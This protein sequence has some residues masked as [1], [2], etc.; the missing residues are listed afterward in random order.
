MTDIEYLNNT[1]FCTLAP[2]AIHGVGVFAVRDI[3]RGTAYT[4]CTNNNVM[5]TRYYTLSTE[6]FSKLHP[7]IQSLI[8][9]RT[10]FETDLIEFISPNNDAIL[11]SFMNHSDT[12]NTDGVYALRD[13]KA[14]EELT[15]DFFA[16]VPDM[17]PRSR[18]HFNHFI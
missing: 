4:D 7:A 16:L 3:P 11:R 9:D 10:I 17:H 6:Q 1:V 14:G 8:L 15:E 13:I 2:S 5:F 12:P 18:L